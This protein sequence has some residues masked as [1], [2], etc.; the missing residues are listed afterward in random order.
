MVLALPAVAA[1]KD[2][3]TPRV[4]PRKGLMD[5]KRDVQI[6]RVVVKF[7][8]GTRVRLRGGRLAQL[9]TSATSASAP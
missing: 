6:P 9:A 4:L 3:L 8:E 1:E 5:L 7:H 2:E